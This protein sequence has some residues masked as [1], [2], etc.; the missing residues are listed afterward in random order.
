MLCR[1][2]NINLTVENKVIKENICKGCNK[3]KHNEWR[4]RK[5]NNEPKLKQVH[6]NCS[7]C[8]NELT[9]DNY[10]KDRTYC[11]EC[12]SKKYQ[13]YKDILINNNDSND[14]DLLCNKCSVNLTPKNQVKGRKYCKPCD[15][16]RRNESKKLHKDEIKIQHKAYYEKNKEK[17]KEH[18]QQYYINNKE[19]YLKNNQQWRNKNKVLINIKAK[20]RL[21]NDENYRLRRNLRNRLHT[22]IKKDKPTMEY[23]GCD[24]EFLKK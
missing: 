22:C 18:S 23:I 15:N 10:L 8:N 12:R 13:K 16:K 1:N 7:I 17:I 3:I 11:K 6:S 21:V 5:K 9:D 4:V 19:T 14:N 2:C 20:I 24:L